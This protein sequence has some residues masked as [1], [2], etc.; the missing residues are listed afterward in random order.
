MPVNVTPSSIAR[1]AIDMAV[2][3]S[4]PSGSRQPH[5]FWRGRR[6]AP[7]IAASGDWN[8]DNNSPQVIM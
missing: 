4:G 6:T 2:G 1:R 3:R 7:V 5:D 8:D